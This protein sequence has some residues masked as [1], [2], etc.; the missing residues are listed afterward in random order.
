MSK[1]Q[2]LWADDEIDLLKPHI[3]FLNNKGYEVTTVTN[4]RDAL[5]L[6]QSQNFDLII[7][8]EPLHGLDVSHKK[9]AAAIIEQ[10]CER[11]GKTLIYVTHYPHELPACVDHHFELVKH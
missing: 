6:L 5:D 8:D 11:P 7:L 10:F 2:I 1:E 9:Q 3:L 4:G